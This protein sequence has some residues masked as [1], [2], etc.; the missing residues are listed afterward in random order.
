MELPQQGRYE[1]IRHE[2]R[3][4]LLFWRKFYYFVF[5][6]IIAT[7]FV[8]A[9]SQPPVE[10]KLNT[11][12]LPVIIGLSAKIGFFYSSPSAQNIFT[13]K[14]EFF[15]IDSYIIIQLVLLKYPSVLRLNPAEIGKAP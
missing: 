15:I 6:T 14:L 12:L 11:E 4:L 7:F 10:A 8:F 2:M 9:Q 3:D 5:I 1:P 13:K